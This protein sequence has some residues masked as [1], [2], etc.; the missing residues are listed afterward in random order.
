[1][2]IKFDPSKLERLNSPERYKLQNPELIWEKIEYKN[3]KV[4]IDIG[5]GTGYFS[6]PLCDKMENGI[7]YACDIS[8]IMINYMDNELP[9]EYKDRIIPVQMLEESKIPLDRN[10]ADVV[11]LVNV[12]HELT[13]PHDMLNEINNLLKN[14]GLVLIIDWKDEDMEKGPPQNIRV[15]INTA[16][17]QLKE[18]GFKNIKSHE[19]FTYQYF[20][21]AEK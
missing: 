8:E 4:I 11:I 20:I 7:V 6:K 13:E 16:M 9:K 18:H 17:E 10:L 15:N 19:V 1:M 14:N 5:A 12:Y 3:P 2:N 21:I